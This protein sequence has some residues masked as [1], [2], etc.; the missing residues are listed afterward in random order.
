MP[1]A[2]KNRGRSEA[3]PYS[4]ATNSTRRQEKCLSAVEIAAM[5]VKV[6][7]LGE[8]RKLSILAQYRGR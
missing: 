4:Y 8:R 3:R 7:W 1:I 6:G 2:K 5:F